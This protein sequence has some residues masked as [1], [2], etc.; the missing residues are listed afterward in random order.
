MEPINRYRSTA[1]LY[2]LDDRGIV[3]DD[4]PFYIERAKDIQGEILEIAC[5]TG[6]VTI[7][8]ARAGHKVAGLDL[9][10][11][12]LQVLENKLICESEDVRRNIELIEGDMTEFEF[13]RQFPF[14]ITPFRAFQLL[15]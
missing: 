10:R 8:L 3:K 7:P 11:N 13:N 4:I 12:M 1:H 15:I 6:R 14:I 5:G 2:D 9:S